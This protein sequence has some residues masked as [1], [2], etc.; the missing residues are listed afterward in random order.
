MFKKKE[1][2]RKFNIG[3]CVIR[4]EKVED[5]Y[6]VLELTSNEYGAQTMLKVPCKIA[7]EIFNFVKEAEAVNNLPRRMDFSVQAKHR[8]YADYLD[9]KGSMYRYYSSKAAKLTC[10]SVGGHCIISLLGDDENHHSYCTT[11]F[12]AYDVVDTIK[13]LGL[14]IGYLSGE[15]MMHQW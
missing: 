11:T 7:K 1:E 4:V 14:Y 5:K 9:G 8:D 15:K 13:K 6:V 12:R 10:M 3:N 2:T